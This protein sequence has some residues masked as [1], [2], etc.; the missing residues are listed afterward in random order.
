MRPRFVLDESSWSSAA[1]ADPDV[2]SSA[3]DRLVERLDVARERDE[4]VAMHQDFYGIDLGNGV[5]LYSVLF[6][7]DCPVRLEHDDSS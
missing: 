5:Q 3:V 6:E 2:L 7:P 4:A 1:E